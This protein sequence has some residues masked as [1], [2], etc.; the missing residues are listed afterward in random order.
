MMK[1]I[2][3]PLKE[4]APESYGVDPTVEINP[5][6]GW[7]ACDLEEHVYIAGRIGW[8]GLKAEEYTPSGPVLLSVPNLNHGDTVDFGKVNHISQ[9]RYD[10]SP[11]IKL[12]QG[13]TLL[14]KDGAG[15]GKLGFVQN[16]P[17]DGTVNSSLLVVRPQDELL[18][19]KY[20]FYYLKGPQF[21]QLALQRITGSATPHLFQKDIKR[22]RVLVPP[23]AEQPRII[24]KL[25]HCLSAV[26]AIRD[27]LSRVPAILKRFRQAVLAAACSGRLTEDWRQARSVGSVGTQHLVDQL[28]D[29]CKRGGGDWLEPNF[30]KR[31]HSSLPEGWNYVAL[32]VLG[33]WGSGGTPSTSNAAYWSQG[34]YPWV[35]PKDMKTDF[36]VESQDHLT[37]LGASQLKV[38][39]K[40]SILFVV[41]GMILAHTFP[42]AMTLR[43]LTINQDIR[44]IA[45]HA[46]VAPKYLLRALQHEAKSILFAVRESTHGT[47]RL[48][49]ETLKAWPI[50]VPPPDEQEAIVRRI[51]ELFQLS[52]TIERFV[53][54]GTLR[55][56]KLTQS[57][58]AKA[59]RGELVS[60]EAELARREGRDYEPASVLLERIK[61]ERESQTSSKPQRK[62]IRPEAKLATTKG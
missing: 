12:K 15:I 62:R 59:F 36:I 45:P 31:E 32:A 38:I 30:D 41:R 50:P 58:L 52:R 57:I 1:P 19:H 16:L 8:R 53:S 24:A 43:E 60:T 17:N 61:K 39:P 4:T 54:S 18:I 51:E 37:R 5:P 13:D 40:D 28:A 49:S 6:E 21:Q 23:R 33:S 35:S 22:L 42:V 48:E 55:V 26:S 46:G 11:E 9:D 2:T 27:H 25:E 29:Q 3:D 7:S 10:E 34:D 14:V 47:R 20:L 56:N 44:S